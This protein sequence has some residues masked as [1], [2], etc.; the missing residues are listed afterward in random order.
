[1]VQ[2]DMMTVKRI[3][4]SFLGTLILSCLSCSQSSKPTSSS[5]AQPQPVKAAELSAPVL[6]AKVYEVSKEDITKIPGITSRNISVEG[7]KLGDRTR[8][9]DKLL[10]KPIKTEKL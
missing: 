4:R 10:G 1:M 3:F 2:E 6:E 9:V 7:V 8:D 5:S